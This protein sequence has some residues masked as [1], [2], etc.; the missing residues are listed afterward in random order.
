MAT[1]FL[2]GSRRFRQG[3]VCCLALAAVLGG[4]LATPAS[5]GVTVAFVPVPAAAFQVQPAVGAAVGRTLVLWGAGTA[6]A[7]IDLAEPTV[8]LVFS[9]RAEPC[10]GSP[11]LDVRVDGLSVFASEVAGAGVY[12]VRG[13]WA[14]GHHTLSFAFPNDQLGANCDRNVKIRSVGMWTSTSGSPYSYVEQKLDL[15]AVTFS[16]VSAG[17][18]TAPI[19][20]LYT[21]GSFVGPLDS[22]AA[23]HFSLRLTAMA[24]A[25]LPRFRLSID[26]VVITEQEV[27]ASSVFGPYGGERVYTVDRSWTDG[28]HKVQVTYLND[29]R[30]ATCD[31]NLSVVSAKFYGTV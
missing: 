13:T 7:T 2:T 19:A 21:N 16:P 14:T 27:P 22:Q 28:V 18:G 9:A 26:D 3:L 23:R 6:H 4:L 10:E 24:C 29:L 5:A 31:R 12:A 1:I 25:G 30:T 17:F 20:R 11:Q 15:A 8:R